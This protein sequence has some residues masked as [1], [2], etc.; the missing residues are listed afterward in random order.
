[1]Y[2]ITAHQRHR[3]TDRQTDVKRSHDRYI[4]KACSGKN[5]I[6]NFHRVCQRKKMWKSVEN[7]Q[8][9]RYHL[10]VSV[11]CNTV[12]VYA[13]AYWHVLWPKIS[14]RGVCD[15]GLALDPARDLNAT[16]PNP[17]G[18]GRENR[19]A[20]RGRRVEEGTERKMGK[21]GSGGK[22][23]VLALFP[24]LP[25]YTEYNFVHATNLRSLHTFRVK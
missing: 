23:P 3:R 13:V 24:R 8:S 2:V 18:L 16:S 11:V 5:S 14:H 7:W 19:R 17:L 1:M 20:K 9:Y 21:R 12:G 25:E 22:V 10:G 4:A 6:A 15:R